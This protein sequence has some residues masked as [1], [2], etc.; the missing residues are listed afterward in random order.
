[1]KADTGNMHRNSL[2]SFRCHHNTFWT[3][4]EHLLSI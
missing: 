3:I 4:T 2:C 1:M